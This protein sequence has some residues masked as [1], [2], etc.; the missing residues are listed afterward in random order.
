MCIT[1]MAWEICKFWSR[2]S[3]WCEQVLLLCSALQYAACLHVS[4]YI[5]Q[6]WELH[7]RVVTHCMESF[8]K[9]SQHEHDAFTQFYWFLMICLHIKERQQFKVTY[10]L[11][12]RLP[13]CSSN[14]FSNMLYSAD[15]SFVSS[16]SISICDMQV[17]ETLS[18]FTLLEDTAPLIS[19]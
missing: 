6:P 15:I 10:P 4:E 2:G 19:G 12:L 7:H 13:G 16:V 11:L 9:Y 18:F 8:L 3:Y 1:L 5:H 14:F 17:T